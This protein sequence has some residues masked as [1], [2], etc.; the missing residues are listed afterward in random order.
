MEGHAQ[1][2]CLATLGRVQRRAGLPAHPACYPPV[3][4]GMSPT[5]STDPPSSSVGRCRL[6]PVLPPIVVWFGMYETAKI[7]PIHLA[8]FAPITQAPRPE[9][10]GAR[11]ERI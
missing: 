5:C 11:V 2:P 4:N 8:C 7:L 9:V 6:W 3:L 1:A 10:R